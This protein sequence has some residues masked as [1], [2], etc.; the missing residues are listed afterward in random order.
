MDQEVIDRDFAEDVLR[1]L[2]AK[3]KFL[4]SRYFYDATGDRLFQA[5]M[6]SQ[7]YYLTDCELEILET[8][9]H[10]IATEIASGGAFELVELGSG[11]GSK[12]QYFL[13]ALRNLGAGFCFQPVD[14]S[15]HS[16]E[17]LERRLKPGRD[18]LDMRPLNTNYMD[19]LGGLEPGPKRRVFAFMG[20][21]LGNF[22][23]TNAV[24][25][26]ATIRAAMGPE[27]ALLIGLDLKKPS[28]VIR[29]AYDDEAGLTR[30]FNLNLLTRINRELGADFDLG[31]F[32][33]CPHY[34]PDSGAAT[35]HLRSEI[36][37]VV[38][39]D[40]LQHQ[41]RFGAGER[42]FMEISQKYD[43]EM[44]DSIASEAGFYVA[45]AFHDSRHWFTNQ[46]WRPRQDLPAGD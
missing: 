12:I 3:Q 26:L 7:E 21:N 17:L 36:D 35:S 11:D 44:I 28:E 45:R 31:A 38:W 20:S 33:H 34:D 40:A 19:W 46:V 43:Q 18:W 2:G 14:I 42:V 1:G 25:F 30:A 9:S 5:I 32:T 15:S 4:L 29:A 23:R 24:A 39:I 27:D 22:T 16:L 6:A 37:Q 13:D 41:F 10:D 8:Q